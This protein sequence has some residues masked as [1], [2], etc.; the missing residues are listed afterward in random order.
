MCCGYAA[1]SGCYLCCLLHKPKREQLRGAYGLEEKPSDI[2]A[3]CCCSPC[4][5]CQ[6]AREMKARGLLK[7][8]D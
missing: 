6:E 5:V 7:I 8:I 2:L 1:L 3:T 4:G